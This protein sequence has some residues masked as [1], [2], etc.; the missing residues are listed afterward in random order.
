M[1]LPG[2]KETLLSEVTKDLA[3]RW[4]IQIDVTGVAVAPAANFPIPTGL[5]HDEQDWHLV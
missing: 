5:A 3:A 4:E 1:G 2:S